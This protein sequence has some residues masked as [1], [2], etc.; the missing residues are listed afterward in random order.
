[1]N[2]LIQVPISFGSDSKDYVFT[3]VETFVEF[4]IELGKKTNDGLM[5][6]PKTK[7]P[8]DDFKKLPY[9]ALAPSN[10]SEIEVLRYSFRK[11]NGEWPIIVLASGREEVIQFLKKEGWQ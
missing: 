7:T 8:Y 1:M 5:R 4:V 3:D 9:H 2:G 11:K 10:N 6:M